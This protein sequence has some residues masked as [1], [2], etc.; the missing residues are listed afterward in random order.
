MNLV[1]DKILSAPNRMESDL[2]GSPAIDDALPTPDS[3]TL[4]HVGMRL[5]SVAIT[6]PA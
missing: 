3:C 1:R 6:H 2:Y 4:H 5:A